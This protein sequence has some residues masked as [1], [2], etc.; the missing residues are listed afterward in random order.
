MRGGISHC[1][2]A[3]GGIGILILLLGN[4]I[5]GIFLFVWP[6]SAGGQTGEIID[7]TLLEKLQ[8]EYGTTTPQNLRLP[9]ISATTTKIENN[10]RERAGGIKLKAEQPAGF[11]SKT[12]TSTESKLKIGSTIFALAALAFIFWIYWRHK[13]NGGGN[14]NGETLKEDSH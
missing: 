7:Y 2:S 1:A 14:G 8:M 3:F 9:Q 12:A 11:V 5:C 10:K 4:I 6:V 13:N